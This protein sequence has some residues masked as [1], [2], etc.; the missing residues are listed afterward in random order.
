MPTEPF[1][2]ARLLSESAR[3]KALTHAQGTLRSYRFAWKWFQAWCIH[4]EREALPA[5]QETVVLYLTDIMS[6]GRRA[7][8]AN[9][10]A[11]AINFEHCQQNYPPPAGEAVKALL[12]GARRDRAE[13]PKPKQ[14][15]TLDL[16]RRICVITA[17]GSS[18]LEVRDHALI[19]LGFAS[20][21]RRSTVCALDMADIAF[22]PQGLVV[23][24]RREK[25]DQLGIGR[26][27]GISRGLHPETCAVAALIR[28]LKMRGDDAGPLFVPVRGAK[29]KLHPDT[30]C[31][32]VKHGVA[33]VNLA[34]GLFGFHSLRSGFVTTA[35]EAN[36]HPLVICAQTGHRSLDSLK[37]YFHSGDLFRASG[38][39]G[40]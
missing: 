17:E 16:L 2:I 15:I 24:V 20:A 12:R 31:R 38:S 36:V 34:P 29:R 37:R 10:R 27:L 14:A 11:A 13:S 9:L 39:I 26:T 1:S 22:A 33:L 5:S 3:L 40:L 19:T 23:Y 35:G 8:T 25:T 6:Q 28:W 7:V 32:A 18:P 4:A 21:L 30:A